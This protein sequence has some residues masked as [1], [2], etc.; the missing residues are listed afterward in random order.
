MTMDVYASL[1][2]RPERQHGE[3]FD[4]LGRKASEWLYGTLQDGRG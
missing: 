3:A 4:C 1:Q 2:Q